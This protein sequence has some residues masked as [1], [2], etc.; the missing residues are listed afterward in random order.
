MC[1]CFIHQVK[2]AIGKI[3][4]AAGLCPNPMPFNQVVHLRTSNPAVNETES[5]ALQSCCCCVSGSL[6]LTLDWRGWEREGKNF[7]SQARPPLQK[8]PPGEHDSPLRDRG[9]G[10]QVLRNDWS[11][12][13]GG[14]P[15]PCHSGHAALDL[16]PCTFSWLMLACGTSR[17]MWISIA[18][19]SATPSPGISPVP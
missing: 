4:S 15:L 11:L 10:S 13:W 19:C 14:A 8:W 18:C 2:C 6:L 16:W 1:D 3:F 5:W 9:T 17:Q 12:R 7:P